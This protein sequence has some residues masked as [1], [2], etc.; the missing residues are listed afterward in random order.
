MPH[1]FYIGFNEETRAGQT[2]SHAH[3]HIIPCRQGD[4]PDP[5]KGVRWVVAESASHWNK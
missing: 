1:S 4:V 2:V 5:R 3:I